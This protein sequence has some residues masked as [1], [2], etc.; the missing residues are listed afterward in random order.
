M[1]LDPAAVLLT[2]TGALAPVFYNSSLYDFGGHVSYRVGN[3]NLNFFGGKGLEIL[4][5]E[6][7]LS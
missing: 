1:F 3:V 2:K 4:L 7:Y 5:L 6:S